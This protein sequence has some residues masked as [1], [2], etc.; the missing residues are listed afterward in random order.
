LK[1]SCDYY[2][3][4][5]ANIL[6]KYANRK[7]C[8]SRL[9]QGLSITP[10]PSISRKV[11][12]VVAVRKALRRRNLVFVGSM[13]R[14]VCPLE[15]EVLRHEKDSGYSFELPI[16]NYTKLSCARH[17][18]DIPMCHEGLPMM[19]SI[20]AHSWKACEGLQHVEDWGGQA[21]Q[22]QRALFFAND[23]VAW[24]YKACAVLLG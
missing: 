15:E 6:A 20:V 14:T 23:G 7:Y 5:Q 1:A 21:Q 2:P 22:A 18:D 17:N 13:P 24:L 3:F 9:E 4:K 8:T 16:A 10:C 19:S 12:E 11:D